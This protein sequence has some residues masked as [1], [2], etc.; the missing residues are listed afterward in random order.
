MNTLRVVKNLAMKRQAHS[1]KSRGAQEL[2]EN[3]STSFN[4]FASR[5]GRQFSSMPPPPRK[6][7]SR[8]L[9]NSSDFRRQTSTCRSS[10]E[11]SATHLARCLLQGFDEAPFAVR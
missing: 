6:P 7:N 4:G 2:R 9:R 8:N 10:I 3:S 5:H 1:N 11:Q